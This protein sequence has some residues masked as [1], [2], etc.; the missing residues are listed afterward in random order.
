[1]LLIEQSTVTIYSLEGDYLNCISIDRKLGYGIHVVE[2][3]SGSGKTTLLKALCGI[4]DSYFQSDMK[5][6]WQSIPISQEVLLSS[7]VF[8]QDQD[9]RIIPG[10]VEEG[11]MQT[12]SEQSSSHLYYFNQLNLSSD[13]L[14]KSRDQ[15]S[16]G[17]IARVALAQGLNSRRPLLVLDEPL[18]SLDKLNRKV[19]CDVLN[20]YAVNA[21][22][23]CSDHSGELSTFARSQI[24]IKNNAQ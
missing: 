22:V 11:L 7:I 9:P 2:G 19:V 5:I 8:Y 21:V 16:G 17:Q 3:E 18:A 15:L 14:N 6:S 20:D 4:H 13:I 12:N 1:M 24:V 10:T 23:I